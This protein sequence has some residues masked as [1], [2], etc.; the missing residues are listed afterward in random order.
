ELIEAQLGIRLGLSTVQLYLRR[1]GMTP[2]RP[3]LRARERSPA[4]IK[5]WLEQDYPAIAARAKREGA[6]IYW[7]DETG[8]STVDQTGRAWAPRGQTPVVTRQARRLGGSMISA[9]SNRGLMRF[10]LYDGA[11][12]AG[13]F[14]TFMRRLVND[15]KGK[16]FL[17]VDNLRVHHARKVKAWAAA[18]RHEIELFHL[19]A[20]APEHNPD[21]HPT[22]TSSSS[23]RKSRSPAARTS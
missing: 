10:M 8:L 23:C 18:H 9:V 2:Q 15:T 4:A 21:E 11:L 5:A 12:N 1:W 22:T 6:V 7:G 13:L 14:V 19:P 16:V 20:Y 17:I 3:L